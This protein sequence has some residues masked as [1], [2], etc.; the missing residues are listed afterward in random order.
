MSNTEKRGRWT[1]DDISRNEGVSAV[2]P[3]APSFLF[4]PLPFSSSEEAYVKD[5]AEDQ[6]VISVCL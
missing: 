4:S 3:G 1:G 2:L 5:T 6:L